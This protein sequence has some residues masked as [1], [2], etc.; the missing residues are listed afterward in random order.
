MNRTRIAVF[1][2]VAVAALLVAGL[3]GARTSSGTTSGSSAHNLAVSGTVTFDGV[4]TGS[5]ATDFGKVIA[6]FNKI[7][8]KVHIKYNPLGNNVST[9]LATA[10][11]G[12][13]PPDMAD[14]AQPGYVKQL[15]QQGHL[16][17]ITYATSSISANFAP[18]VAVA[19]HVQREA[20]RARLQ[21]VQ[22]V[23]PL[24][25]RPGLQGR[26]RDSRRRRGRSSSPMRRR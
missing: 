1:A 21:G 15:V 11:A 8:P 2:A 23:A 17:P 19:R 10:I 12:G 24:V 4:W 3:A 22:Q 16:K 6:A 18:V 9:V 20:L 14:I 5:E 7:Y 25:Q 13:H 26:R